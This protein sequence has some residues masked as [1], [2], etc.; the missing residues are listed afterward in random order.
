MVS[1][2]RRALIVNEEAARVMGMDSP[3]GQTI[4]RTVIGPEGEVQEEGTIVGVL[5]NFHHN[6]FH[7]NI[8]P[9]IYDLNP[10]GALMVCLRTAPGRISQVLS[11]LESFWKEHIPDSPFIYTFLD[12]TIDRFYRTEQRMG[13]LFNTFTFLAVVIACLGLFG[14]ASF[15][16][17][18]KTKEIGIRKTLGASVPGIVLLLARGFTK[19]VCLAVLFAWPLAWLIMRS[20]LNRFAFRINMGISVFL[21]SAL[22]AVAVALAAIGYQTV[23]A[24]LFDPV[25]T[26]RYE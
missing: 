17:E 24:A 20:W 15:T 6:S 25:K 1:D 2:E 7:K 3:L 16:A 10:D 21:L 8:Q 4:T 22:G 26:L 13:R 11:F 23:K 18:K 12:E 19:W 5:K 14:L 9:V